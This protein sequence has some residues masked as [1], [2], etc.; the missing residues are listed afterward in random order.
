[1]VETERLPE[2][3]IRLPPQL[4]LDFIRRA[5]EAAGVP[6]GDA[7]LVADVLVSADLRGIRSHGLARIGYF[8]VRLEHGTIN[9]SPD[10]RLERGSHTTA[11]LW[12]DDAIGIVAASAAMDEAIAMATEHGSGFVSVRDASHFGYAG[13]WTMRAMRHGFIGIAMASGGRRVTPTFGNESVFGTNPMSVAIPGFGQTVDFNL[14]MATSAVAVG[15]IETALREGRPVEP[16][17]VSSAGVPPALDDNGVLTYASPLL[18]LGGEGDATGGHKGYG[19]ALMIELLA[20]A[21][22]GSPLSDRIAGAAGHTRTAMGQF[23]GAISVAGFSPVSEVA[24]TMAGTFDLVRSAEKSPG[25]DRIFI[26]GEPESIAE[27]RIR[28]EGI[29]VT[30][31]MLAQLRKWNDH[32]HLGFDL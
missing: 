7:D 18:P 1:M 5:F 20:G 23:M 30:P 17:W 15:K 12:A 2:G 31:A 25:H 32:F 21:L 24:S 22:S 28:R 19:L 4:A 8:M 3:T 6:P 27:E 9:R 26:H 29:A 16:G 13:Y 11:V 14:D 10:M